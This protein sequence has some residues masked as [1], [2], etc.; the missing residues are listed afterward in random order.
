MEHFS[1]PEGHLKL[2]QYKACKADD[3]PTM[4]YLNIIA[5]ELQLKLSMH[6][7]ASQISAA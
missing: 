1:A 2:S 6:Q 3:G 4:I 7:Q 5:E